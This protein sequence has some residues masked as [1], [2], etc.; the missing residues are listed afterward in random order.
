MVYFRKCRVR[1]FSGV[2]LALL[3]MM[4]A[5]GGCAALYKAKGLPDETMPQPAYPDIHEVPAERPDKTMTDE[6]RARTEA[7]LKDLATARQRAVE[8]SLSSGQ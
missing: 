3:L 1:L 6:E 7:E 5:L 4:P 8:R 2:V